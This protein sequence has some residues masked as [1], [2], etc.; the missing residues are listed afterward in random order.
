MTSYP[1]AT[2]QTLRGSGHRVT[3]PMVAAEGS[4]GYEAAASVTGGG[5]GGG[6]VG[7]GGGDGVAFGLPVLAGLPELAGVLEAVAGAEQRMLDAVVGL[8]RLLASDE[9]AQATGVPVEQWLGIVCRLTRMDRRLLLRL[10]RLLERF[11]ALRAGVEAGRVSF[12]QLRGVGMVLRQAPAVIDVDLDRLLVRLLAEL[13][14]A[15][16]DVLVDQVRQAI[17]ELLPPVSVE[18]SETITNS[19]YLQPNLSRTGGRFAGEYDAAGM[20]ILDAA[21]APS[22]DQLA[23]PN[24]TRG[25]RADN[26]LARLTHDCAGT[27]TSAAPDSDRTDPSEPD[28]DAARRAEPAGD[29][30]GAPAAADQPGVPASDADPAD[31]AAGAGGAGAGVGGQRPSRVQAGGLL[32]PVKLLARVQLE[33]LG[34]LPAD[35][36][37]HLTGGQLKLSSQA[38]RSLLDE[39]GVELRLVVVDQGEVV[40][41]G[42]QSRLPPGW[43][44]DIALAV[45]DTCTEPLCERPAR[46][47]HLDHATPWW[48]NG[49]DGPYGTT[50]TDNIGPLCGTTNQTKETTG[51]QAIQTG[52][53]RRTWTHV[54]TGLTITTVPATWRPAGWS[55]P[56]HHRLPGTPDRPARSNSPPERERT[57]PPGHATGPPRGEPPDPGRTTPPDGSTHPD[58]HEAAYED[59]RQAR[60]LPPI[61]TVPPPDPDDLPF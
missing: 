49:P 31:T 40:G 61:R 3:R 42:R 48:P 36:L 2:W 13:V 39:R 16:P 10:G 19:L 56:C 47:A 53:G 41:V 7:G 6:A 4:G 60:G 37:T 1:T 28:A 33:T 11:P 54:P 57:R 55:P 35:L 50:D 8:S 34:A 20:A 14:G 23:H 18:E 15:D 25:A 46:S 52:D 44:R 51:W 26:L 9:V 27:D 21:T 24:G 22:R 17:V 58:P 45:H 30:A 12:A 32:P 29:D 59:L 38:A 5:A 43:M